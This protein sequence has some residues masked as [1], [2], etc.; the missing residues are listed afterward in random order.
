[1]LEYIG[2][3]LFYL[4]V[5]FAFLIVLAVF[6]AGIGMIVWA[7][8]PPLTVGFSVGECIGI[9]LGGLSIMLRG[10][11]GLLRVGPTFVEMTAGIIKAVV[12]FFKPERRVRREAYVPRYQQR[13]IYA[14][15][16]L[17]RVPVERPIHDSFD[18]MAEHR[19]NFYAPVDR[20]ACA[21]RAAAEIEDKTMK[22]IASDIEDARAKGESQVD[23][24]ERL[25]GPISYER[26]VDPVL[27]EDGF[28]YERGQIEGWLAQSNK[29][30]MTRE[31]MG[32]S[33]HANAE[34][35]ALLNRFEGQEEAKLEVAQA[36]TVLG[37]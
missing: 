16:R 15:L 35:K 20:Q 26:M 3:F 29:S 11:L 28:T 19:H 6:T 18:P 23:L 13:N 1:M 9:G 2:S 7:C 22:A 25:Q 8:I 37:R 12:S 24:T 34:M 14:D 33:L 5:L 27:A 30:P 32:R 21:P 4:L 10:L 17:D 31:V 36:G